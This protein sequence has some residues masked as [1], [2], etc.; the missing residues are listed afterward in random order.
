MEDVPLRDYVER[1]IADQDRRI[2]QALTASRAAV[3]KAEKSQ[4]RRLDL[5]NEFR[6]QAADESAKYALRETVDHLAEAQDTRMKKI[7][8]AQAWAYGGIFVLGLIGVG[9]LI[10]L[11]AGR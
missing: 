5:L 2:E 6:A 1:I 7:E 9:T 10:E 11:F 4:E 8:R 3:D